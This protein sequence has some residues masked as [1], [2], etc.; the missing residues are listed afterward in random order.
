M[1]ELISFMME[2]RLQGVI[3]NMLFVLI[4]TLKLFVLRVVLNL[5]T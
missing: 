5:S 4:L 3:L 1:E 2:H